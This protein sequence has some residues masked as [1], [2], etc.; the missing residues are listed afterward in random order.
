[1]TLALNFK[2][3]GEYFATPT[4]LPVW[5]FG[6]LWEAQQ[7]PPFKAQTLNKTVKLR[8]LSYLSLFYKLTLFALHC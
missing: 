1:M 2:Q 6:G 4:S 3:N 5:Y 7:K 8:L